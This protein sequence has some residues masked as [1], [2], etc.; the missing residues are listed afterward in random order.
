MSATV[1]RPMRIIGV[2]S[3]KGGVGKSHVAANLAV[4]AS[5][6]GLRTLIIDADLGLGSADI[7]LGIHAKHH[8]GHVLE[9]A[10]TIDGAVAKGPEEVRLLAAST[11]HQELTHLDDAQK[12]RLVAA[13][14][15]IES[16]YDVV[17]VDAGAGIGA[18]V[19]FF[20]GAAHEALLVVSP[21]PT[22]LADAYADRKSVV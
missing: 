8:L 9:G 14:D 17:I 2:A 15:Q 19:L 7:L 21:E 20:V 13:V 11:G 3:G 6:Q 10:L 4:Y 12:L 16:T 18:N 5:K 1:K 22:A